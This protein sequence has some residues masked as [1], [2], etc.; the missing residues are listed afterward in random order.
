M[1]L[2]GGGW[3]RGNSSDLAKSLSLKYCCWNALILGKGNLSRLQSGA[4]CVSV[5]KRAFQVRDGISGPEP[6][7]GRKAAECQ[8]KDWGLGRDGA[9]LLLT[10][11]GYLQLPLSVDKK[12]GRSLASQG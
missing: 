1:L 10:I 4:D 5:W 2:F 7:Q 8:E 9:Q 3:E 6:G 12:P 11:S